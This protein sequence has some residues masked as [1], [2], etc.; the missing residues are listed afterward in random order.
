MS[1]QGYALAEADRAEDAIQKVSAGITASQSTGSTVWMPLHL[2]YL[3]RACAG[4]GQFESAWRSLGEA[5][6]AAETTNERWYEAEIYRVAGEIALRAPAPDFVKAEEY[7]E[8]ALEIART[9]Q[10]KSWELRAAISLARLWCRQGKRQQA[11]DGLAPIYGWFTEGFDTTDLRQAKALLDDLASDG[12]HETACPSVRPILGPGLPASSERAS[13][14]ALQRAE[15]QLADRAF[16]QRIDAHK[17]GK[18]HGISTAQGAHAEPHR[19]RRHHRRLKYCADFFQDEAVADVRIHSLHA[20]VLRRE[21]D[22]D[23][24]RGLDGGSACGVRQQPVQAGSRFADGDKFVPDRI[25]GEQARRKTEAAMHR[26]VGLQRIAGAT[27][28]VGTAAVPLVQRAE[29]KL[30]ELRRGERCRSLLPDGAPPF[31]DERVRRI[32]GEQPAEVGL[33][34]AG[35]GVRHSA[36]SRRFLQGTVIA[37]DR[38]LAT[39][40][41]CIA[42]ARPSMEK[43]VVS[44][45]AVA[46]AQIEQPAPV[47]QSQNGLNR[48]R[49]EFRREFIRRRSG[50]EVMQKR[51][52]MRGH[53]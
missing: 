35:S 17:L 38:D 51:K 2:S 44:G 52:Q 47:H 23:L 10:A 19:S 6:T 36:V 21:H 31:G 42:G 28:R 24:R 3:A 11:R 40:T 1:L 34:Q 18:Q 12:D 53:E 50:R 16:D 27:A 39:Q 30:R 25:I 37:F 14:R 20:S 15:H 7:F 9:Q 49:R 41:S 5:M 8:R 32:L 48:L 29:Q 46:A 4:L 13:R 43:Q 22:E 26:D 33:R 45:P